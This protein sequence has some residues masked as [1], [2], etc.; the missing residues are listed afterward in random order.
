MY[1]LLTYAMGNEIIPRMVVCPRGSFG[2][3]TYN[4]YRLILGYNNARCSWKKFH[5]MQWSFTKIF[6]FMIDVNRIFTLL[7]N[8]YGMREDS[9]FIKKK[10][11]NDIQ[12][13]ITTKKKYFSI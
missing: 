13:Q 9:L 12:I 8:T 1:F 3:T 10:L 2:L 5:L 7:T 11:L 4:T 6:W